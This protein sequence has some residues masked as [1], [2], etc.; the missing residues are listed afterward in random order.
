MMRPQA[1]KL[2]GNTNNC[3]Y[4]FE[5]VLE[6][7]NEKFL[8]Q[9]DGVGIKGAVNEGQYDPNKDGPN[10]YQ[11]AVPGNLGALKQPN[12]W[13]GLMKYNMGNIGKA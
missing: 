7:D 4:G 5:Q 11:Y 1:Y 8:Y 12:K 10:V 6:Q 13:G 2:R 9:P 3:G